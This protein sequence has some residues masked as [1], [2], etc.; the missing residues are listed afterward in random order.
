MKKIP[1]HWDDLES[2]F[3]RNSPDTESF[4]DLTTGR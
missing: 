4:L 1:I 3:E 2:A